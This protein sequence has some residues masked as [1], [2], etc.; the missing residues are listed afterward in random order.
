[1]KPPIAFEEGA[2]ATNEM[3]ATPSTAYGVVDAERGR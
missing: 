1:M 2:V 3:L